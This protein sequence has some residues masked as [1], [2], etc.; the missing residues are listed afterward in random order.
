MK[1]GWAMLANYAEIREGVAYVMSGGIDTV[2]ANAL[3]TTFN[4]AILLRL[5]L[6]RTEIDRPHTI[7]V[8]FLDEDAKQLAMLQGQLE[9]LKPKPDFPVGWQHPVMLALNIRG[10]PLPREC[11]YSAEILGDG[12]YLD[13]VNLRVKLVREASAGLSP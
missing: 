5:M 7:E 11:L 9:P 8:R 6:H 12:N 10:L 1:L 4:G 13:S 2:N 3:P